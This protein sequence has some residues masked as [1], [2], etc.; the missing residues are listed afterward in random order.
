LLLRRLLLP[1]LLLPLLLLPLLL[2]A[3][4][5]GSILTLFFCAHCFRNVTL[6]KAQILSIKVGFSLF[7][8]ISIVNSM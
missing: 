2:L 3:S 7:I 5:D 1:L 4:G 8:Q 6:N